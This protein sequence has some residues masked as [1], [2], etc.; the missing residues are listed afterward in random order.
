[1]ERRKMMWKDR[2]GHLE[3]K[4]RGLGQ[5][6]SAGTSPAKTLILDF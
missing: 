3:A 4:E 5:V 6:S 1:M 2:D